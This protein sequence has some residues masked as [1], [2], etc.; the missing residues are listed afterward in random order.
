MIKEA[1]LISAVLNERHIGPLLNTPNVDMLFNSYGDVWSYMKDYYYSNRQVVPVEI[2]QEQ[3]SDFKHV[4][5]THGTVKHYLEELREDYTTNMLERISRGLAK[6]VGTVSNKELI[7]NLQIFMSDLTKATSGIKDLDIT[8]RE[9]SVEHY[10]DI[11]EKMIENGGVLGI[12]SGFDSIDESYPS[13]WAPGNY[14]VIMSRTNQGKSWVAL[15]LAIAAWL[16]QKKVLY[17]S[18]EMS[19]QSVR[20]RAYSLMS[21]GLFNISD[22]SRAQIDVDK[23]EAWSEDTFSSNGSFIVSSTDSMGDFTPAQLQAKIDQYGPDIVFID[24]LQLMSDNNGSSGETEKIRNTSKQLKSSALSNEI[25][26]ITVAAASSNDTKE[27]NKPPE[28]FECAGSKQAVYDTDLL[29][30]LFSY[31]QA[32]GTLKTEVVARK[33]RNGPLFDFILRMDIA[34]GI[35]AEEWGEENDLL[36][37]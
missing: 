28:I 32:D 9:K 14:V 3:F 5:E 26:I 10:T 17:I 21:K 6:N 23:L 8:D 31:K 35:I 30:S 22:L 34:G 12:R 18:L 33:N 24:Y 16:Q 36:G 19:P 1:R 29:L 7:Q 4:E 27:Y 37:D 2:V 25:P 11:K 15:T 20:D 13:G